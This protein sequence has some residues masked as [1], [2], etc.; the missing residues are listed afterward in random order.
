[1]STTTPSEPPAERVHVTRSR[2]KPGGTAWNIA[3]HPRATDVVA[4]VSGRPGGF[5]VGK[6]NVSSLQAAFQK[7]IAPPAPPTPTKKP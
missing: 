4:R 6:D 2:A 5:V 3:F 7:A 1:M